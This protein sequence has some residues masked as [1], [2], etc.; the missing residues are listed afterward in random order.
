[1]RPAGRLPFVR[2]A[3]RAGASVAIACLR[4]SEGTGANRPPLPITCAGC[5]LRARWARARRPGR[6]ADQFDLGLG[7]AGQARRQRRIVDAAGELLPVA[8]DVVQELL[9]RRSL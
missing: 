5:W 9:E 8:I 1:M 4:N 3:G 7:L 6:P 2:L